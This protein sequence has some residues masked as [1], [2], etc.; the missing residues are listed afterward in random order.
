MHQACQRSASMKAPHHPV[1]STA[2]CP[3]RT[4]WLG[5]GREVEAEDPCA[6]G[7]WPACRGSSPP[8][9]P[10]LPQH[11]GLQQRLDALPAWQSQRH[12]WQQVRLQGHP[13]LQAG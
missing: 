12:L 6:P 3:R 2:A 9:A 8:G 5:S 13:K 4:C 11:H 7:H 1:D 10:K